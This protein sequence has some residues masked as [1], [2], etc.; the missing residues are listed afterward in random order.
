MTSGLPDLK[1]AVR[2]Q[3]ANHLSHLHDHTTVGGPS[4][5]DPV[6]VHIHGPSVRIPVNSATQ[7]DSCRPPREAVGGR[8]ATD[9]FVSDCP[10]FTSFPVIVEQSISVANSELFAVALRSGCPCASP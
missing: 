3:F 6:S 9:A 2:V 5:L 1:P 8:G 10:L 4:F 7:S